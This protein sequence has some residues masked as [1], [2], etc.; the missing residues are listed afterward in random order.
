[1]VYCVIKRRFHRT[2]THRPETGDSL[3]RMRAVIKCPYGTL[4]FFEAEKLTM[5][6]IQNGD[7][8]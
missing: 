1:M 7:P 2:G 6:G 5:G 8:K 4:G 3:F